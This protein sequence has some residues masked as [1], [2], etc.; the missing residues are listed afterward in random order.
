M[1]TGSRTGRIDDS[2]SDVT[3][4]RS[5]GCAFCIKRRSAI[6]GGTLIGNPATN[7]L[8]AIPSAKEEF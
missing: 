6:M 4:D 3:R 1:L 2:A 8:L 5:G 7:S